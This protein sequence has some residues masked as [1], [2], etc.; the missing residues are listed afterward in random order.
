L[1]A[2]PSALALLLMF[3]TEVGSSAARAIEFVEVRDA[4]NVQ[5]DAPVINLSDALDRRQTDTD[6]I[7]IA[8][9]PGNDGIIMRMDVRA[10]REGGAYWAVLALANNNDEMIERLLVAPR[11]GAHGWGLLL[12]WLWQP[13]IVALVPS[14]GERPDHTIADADEIYALTLDPGSV[15]T[16][17]LEL[18]SAE[19]P[20]LM[21][22]ERGAY[23]RDR[24]AA[25]AQ[26]YRVAAGIATLMALLLII[27]GTV[28]WRRRGAT[29]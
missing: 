2:I 9:A 18:R 20:Q 26:Y 12:P 4:V 21:L 10:R 11:D 23:Y 15:N 1:T 13:R 3:A 6:R 22:W 25:V 7:G 19:L 5:I 16:Y 24:L 17:V 28:A 27:T 14:T 29:A 8:A